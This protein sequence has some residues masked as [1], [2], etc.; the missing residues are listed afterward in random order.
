[1]LELGESTAIQCDVR[2]TSQAQL[3]GP[4]AVPVDSGARS[5]LCIIFRRVPAI[6]LRLLNPRGLNTYCGT[7]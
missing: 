5:S 6:L 3:A 7:P 4:I 2:S 1:M